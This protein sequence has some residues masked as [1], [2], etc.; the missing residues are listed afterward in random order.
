MKAF[1]TG[2]T[3]FVGSHVAQA[4]SEQG[5]ELRLLVRPSSDPRNIESL[6]GER[7]VGDL[8]EPATLERAI[9]GCEVIFHVAADYR[10]W[11]RDPE[12]MYRSNVEGT[13]AIL[14]AAAKNQVR[15]VVYTSSVATMGFSS[16][17]QPAD[18]NSPVSLDQMIGPYKRSKFM[19]EQLA[20]QAGRGQL[21]VVVVNPSTPV[22]ERDIK[23]TPT[24]RIIV[25]FLKKKFP[26]Y[27]DTGLNLVDVRECALGH[28]AAFEKGRSGERYIL[29]G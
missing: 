22:G 18:E 2:A 4:L 13:R 9:A 29:G 21:D 24:G 6:P 3:G 17:G 26:A 19:A 11:V 7:V 5:A 12:E 10:L 28:L 1:V 8:R 25:D 14:N 15:R 16:N 20:I 23:P 27:L